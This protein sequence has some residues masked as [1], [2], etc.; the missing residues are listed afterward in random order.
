MRDRPRVLMPAGFAIDDSA[1]GL[2]ITRRW[3][4]GVFIFLAFFCIAWDSF[5]VFWY[6]MAFGGGAPW[7]FKVFP[8]VHLAVGV[9]LTYFT[10]A[11]FLNT[12]TI[13]VA[14]DELTIQHGPLPWFGNHRL[15]VHDLDQ[16]YSQ[17]EM[18][19]N[20]NGV[21]YSY[22]VN[23]VTKGNRKITLV[24]GLTEADQAL[25]IEQQL[26]NYMR[27]K[28]RPVPGELPR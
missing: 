10:L 6:S 28:D 19:R 18:N 1:V 8:I 24:S 20:R 11:G 4:S 21:S 12:T 27:I 3:F 22:K 9:G 13:Q 26:E 16:L 14:M 5:L 23:A 15:S 17:Q 25:F 2:R 7:I